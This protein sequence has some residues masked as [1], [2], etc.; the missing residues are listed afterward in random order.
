M[1]IAR[2]TLFAVS[3][4]L[5]FSPALYASQQKVVVKSLGVTSLSQARQRA[6]TSQFSTAGRPHEALRPTPK[7]HFP[8]ATQAS[9]SEVD[10]GQ[11]V[12]FPVVGPDKWERG[13]T[14][15]TSNDSNVA[16]GGGLNGILE[17]PDQGLAANSSQVF[18]IINLT[19]RIF[20]TSGKPQTEALGIAAFFGVLPSNNATSTNNLSDPRVFFDPQSR[21]F[22]FDILEYQTSN[23]TGDFLSS[24]DLLAVSQTSDATGNYYVYSIDACPT[25]AACLGD[26]P[27]IGVNDDGFFFSNNDFTGTGAGFFGARVVALNKEALINNDAT[28]NGIAY[29]L[30]HD[31]TVEPALPAPGAV[32][33]PNNGTEY[34]TESLDNGP[35]ANGKALRIFAMTNT[36][37]LEHAV[38]ATHLSA[39]NFPTESYSQ[40]LPANQKAGPHPLGQGLGDPLETLNT[41]DDRMLQLYFANGKLFTTL[42]T[43]LNDP[44]D[45]ILRSGAAWFVIEPYS[46]ATT[47]SGHILH[48]GYIGIANGSVLYPAFAA[49]NWGE[50]IIGLSF[51]GTNYFPSAGYVHY[52][53]GTLETRIHTAGA[54]Q[55]PEDGFSGYKQFGATGTARWGDYSAALISPSGHFWFAAEYIPND[56]LYP[57]TAYTNWGTFVSYVP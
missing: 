29:L 16:N 1:K 11:A 7:P 35:P 39:S 54:G 46:T 10:T 6:A 56:I 22:F 19:F 14:G 8:A 55:S 48:Q 31:F 57:R 44:D 45:T 40:P 28:V 30:P 17:P 41:D 24:E 47:V 23:T 42:E 3:A 4:A 15:L 2:F 26:Q 38:V 37:T 13:F 18:E 25:N 49:N 52:N 51:S 9:P 5:V 21:R 50:G 33:T 43:R 36:E 12:E 34:F 32:T 27:L 53:N 20:S